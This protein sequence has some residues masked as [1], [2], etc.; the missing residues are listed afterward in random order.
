MIPKEDIN[1]TL[2]SFYEV[3]SS[4]KNEAQGKVF[5]DAKWS[6]VAKSFDLAPCKLHLLKQ[7]PKCR[8]CSKI[9]DQIDSIIK[10]KAQAVQEIS[11]APIADVYRP[12]PISGLNTLLIENVHSNEYYRTKLAKIDKARKIIRAIKDDFDT[13]VPW[14][15]MKKGTS[16]R[17]WACMVRFTE[18]SPRPDKIEKYLLKAEKTRVLV[19]LIYYIRLTYRPL[20]AYEALIKIVN[21]NKPIDLDNK[22]YS[23]LEFIVHIFSTYKVQ[24]LVLPDIGLSEARRINWKL[25]SLVRPVEQANN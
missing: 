12:N 11:P 25:D 14:T 13:Y 4:L 6:E 10:S 19:F 3:V 7:S 16:S 2:R 21:S 17:F 22:R 15:S 1:E 9:Q 8:T 5:E 20:A 24:G 23:V 18:L